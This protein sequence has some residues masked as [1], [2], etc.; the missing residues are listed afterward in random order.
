[1]IGMLYASYL[2]QKFVS[3]HQ[4]LLLSGFLGGLYSSTMTTFAIAPCARSAGEPLEV[5]AALVAPSEMM[6]VRVVGLVAIFD[7]NVAL[8]VAPLFLLLAAVTAAVAYLMWRRVPHTVHA[9]PVQTASQ[10]N[11]LELNSAALFAIV[12]VVMAVATHY[13]MGA[14]VAMTNASTICA[15]DTGDCICRSRR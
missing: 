1:M 2:I 3:P 12:L 5:A 4:G 6:Y 15:A 7:R 9:A 8:R 11:P 14:S 10:R 13:A